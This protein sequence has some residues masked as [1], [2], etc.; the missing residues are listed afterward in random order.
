M[1]ELYQQIEKEQET[2][3]RESLKNFQRNGLVFSLL[4]V[5]SD[6]LEVG[7]KATTQRTKELTRAEMESRASDVFGFLGREIVVSVV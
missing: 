7:V 3:I 6:T 4:Y 5:D 1:K 2:I